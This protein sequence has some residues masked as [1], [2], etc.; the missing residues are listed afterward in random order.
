MYILNLIILALLHY[1]P[2]IGDPQMTKSPLQFTPKTK[3]TLGIVLSFSSDTLFYYSYTS[4]RN[5][6]LIN[7]NNKFRIFRPKEI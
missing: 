1:V 3:I 5:F 2:K 7:T 4:E 6:N